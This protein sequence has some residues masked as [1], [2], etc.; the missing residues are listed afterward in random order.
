MANIGFTTGSLYR[1]NISFE[2]RIKLYHSLGADAIELSFA[3]PNEFLNYHPSKKSIEDINKFRYISIHA[4]WKE[5]EYDSGGISDEII[6]KLRNLC[7]EFPVYGIVLHPDTIKD[8]TKL[9][10]SELPFL[11]EN[12]DKR[13]RFGTHPEQFEELKRNYDFGFVLD[14]QHGYEQDPSMQFTKELI[15][16]MGRG[17]KHM[18]ISGHTKSGLH[19]PVHLADNKDSITDILKLGI[20]VPKILEGILINDVDEIIKRELR[21]VRGYE[22]D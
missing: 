18:H 3:K 9:K 22:L 5:V 10:N 14:A 2:K 1:S 4:P 12:M 16:V 6:K 19:V 20:K 13:K 15:E 21:Y 7:G 17:L 8:F 11:L